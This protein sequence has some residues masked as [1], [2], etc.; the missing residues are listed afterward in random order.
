MRAEEKTVEMR[1]EEKTVEMPAP[2]GDSKT[3]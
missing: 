3:G 1:A 2:K